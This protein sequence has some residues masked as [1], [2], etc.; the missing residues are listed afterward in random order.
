MAVSRADNS[1][2]GRWWWTVDRWTL[3]AVG[4]LIGFGYIMVL[5]SS[6]SVAERI[7]DARNALI[8][9]QVLFLA[10]AGAIVTAVSL[11]SPRDIR[12]LALVGCIVAVMLTAATLAIGVEIKGARRW[13]ALPGLALQPSEFLKPCFAVVAAWL[14]AEA[15]HPRFAGIS[16][17][18]LGAGLIFLLIVMLL[19]AQPD[20][21]MTAVITAVF[22]AQLYIDG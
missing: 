10:L 2:L 1:L 11:L 18:T 6:P 9:K 17:G 15:R 8:I 19:K 7:G 14:I 16:V 20:V 12:R 4:V 21:G 3:G 22:F 5:A 13:I